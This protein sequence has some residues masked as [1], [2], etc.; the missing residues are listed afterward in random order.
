MQLFR[1]TFVTL[2]PLYFYMVLGI[3][4]R[5]GGVIDQ[6]TALKCNRIIFTGFIPMSV[7]TS[8][9]NSDLHNLSSL[10]AGLFVIITSII[11]FLIF[12]LSIPKLVQDR[13]KAASLIQCLFRTNFVLLGLVYIELMYGREQMGQVSIMIAMIVPILNVLA[14]MNFELLRNGTIQFKNVLK[15]I[16]TNPI[17]IGSILGM[18]FNVLGIRIPDM[19][20]KPINTVGSLASP[21]AMIIVGAMITMEGLRNNRR[22]LVWGNLGRLLFVPGLLLPLAILFGFRGQLLIAILTAL[23]GPT[24]VAGVAMA[25]QL[26]GDAELSSE[27]LA[28]TTVFSTFTL[29]LFIVLLRALG[30]C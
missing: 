30:F 6:S 8:A 1:D 9:Y 3:I 4:M 14:V 11:M 18:L 10:K 15:R 25:S 16:V 23:G 27:L 24:A 20:Y 28:T 2:F 17:I 19:L 29:Y 7:F 12:I 21:F 13:S 26:G 5:K 22:L